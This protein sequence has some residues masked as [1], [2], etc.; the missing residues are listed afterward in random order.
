MAE[1]AAKL[2]E[3]YGADRR[4]TF[5]AAMLHDIA[6]EIPAAE[7]LRLCERYG[8]KPDEIMKRQPD[9][10]H[11][12]LGAEIARR[13]FGLK[14]KDALNAICYHTTGRPGMSLLEKIIF[15]SD[16]IEPNRPGYGGA[17][18]LRELAFADIDRAVAA[19]LESAMAYTS[20]KGK[21]VHPLG[22]KALESVGGESQMAAQSGKAEK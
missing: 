3:R 13:K 14:D 10:T 19:S 17:S 12:M 20:A 16:A 8:L 22:K 15:I 4:G 2:A 6:K 7:K 11:G 1:T 5:L 21:T 9:L 18:G